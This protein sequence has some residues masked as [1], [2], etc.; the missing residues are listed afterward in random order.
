MPEVTVAPARDPACRT[1]PTAPSL[2]HLC[3]RWPPAARRRPAAA[4]NDMRFTPM[5]SQQHECET[6]AAAGGTPGAGAA[7]SAC[8]ATAPS[9]VTI[10]SS[11]K[12]PA[13]ASSSTRMG[14]SPGPPRADAPTPPDPPDTRYSQ[15][16]GDGVTLPASLRLGR[17]VMTGRTERLRRG[18][19]P[20]WRLLPATFMSRR[21]PSDRLPSGRRRPVR[22]A[23][24]PGRW[25]RRPGG[26]GCACSW[27]SPLSG[28]HP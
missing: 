17:R 25:R 24:P 9:A 3:P 8:A 15:L 27:R 2:A 26:R 21:L 14:R 20:S 13:G 22:S 5:S 10:I 23:R 7:V 11:S 6:H 19:M 28:S 1:P 16:D 4:G 12:I 18:P